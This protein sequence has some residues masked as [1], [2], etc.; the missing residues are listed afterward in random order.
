MI[1]TNEKL[2]IKKSVRLLADFV[3]LNSVATDNTSLFYGRAGMSICLFETAYFLNDEYIEEYAFTLLQQ[4]LVNT[5]RGIR[6]DVGLSG[7]GYAL[8]YLIRNKFV[9]AYFEDLFQDQHRIIVNGFIGQD[10]SKMGL[11]DLVVYWNLMSYFHYVPDMQI[12][13]KVEELHD[14]C[15]AKFRM[16]WSQLK[17]GNICLDKE[18]ISA[19]WKKYLKTLSFIDSI[20][21]CQH[22][23]EYLT[24]L[25][26][27]ILKRDIQSLHYLSIIMSKQRTSFPQDIV[28]SSIFNYNPYDFFPIG[29]LT[30]VNM[31]SEPFISCK[32]IQTDILN[33]FTNVNSEVLE[34]E[35][36]DRIGISLSTAVLSF[37]L[38]GLIL[39][40]IS[41]K[42]ANCRIANE[43]LP[44]I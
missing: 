10:F 26:K 27:G 28:K 2:D 9:D 22:I 12:N 38:S 44:L 13:Q 23:K 30:F 17:N 5:K 43:I 20:Y 31:F 8:N 36:T 14:A 40:I 25:Q 24:L 1:N 35:I 7:I 18:L 33:Q 29:S 15:I 6:F 42:S 34:K 16:I 32:S 3:M 37:G 11:K 21:S 39:G 19:L 41:I 4:S